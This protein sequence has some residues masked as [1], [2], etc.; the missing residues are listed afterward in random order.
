[1]D[2]IVVFA[3][4]VIVAYLV[5]IILGMKQLKHFNHVYAQ[6]RQKGRVAIGRRSGKVKAGTLVMFA[7]DQAGT[8][9]DA[10]KMQ[11]VTV[12]AR[13]KEMPQ[14]IG[15]DIHYFDC[16][17]PLIRQ[18]NKLLQVTIEDA[19][20]LFLQIEAGSYQE[21]P[22]YSSALDLDVHVK[23]LMTRLKYQLK[24]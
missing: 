16:Y 5:Q 10:R 22:K 24:K 9:L 18:E 23:G 11:G 2:T 21:A 17:N 8:V 4:I 1:M 13:F 7:I 6:L 3:I 14:F 12:A 15:Q 19:R 20:D